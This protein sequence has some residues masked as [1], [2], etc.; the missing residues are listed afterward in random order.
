[1]AVD[2]V[3]SIE[4]S[5]EPPQDDRPER[6]EIAVLQLLVPQGTRDAGYQAGARR[7]IARSKECDLMPACDKLLGQYG[8]YPFGTSVSSGRHAFPRRRNLCDA[9]GLWL[10]SGAGSVPA[11]RAT[12]R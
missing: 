11:H 8:D 9:H 2:D 7:R 6:S 5:H 1:M 10:W 3:E 4:L 12:G